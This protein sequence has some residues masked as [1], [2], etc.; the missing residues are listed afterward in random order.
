MMYDFSTTKAL[1]TV[2]MC[3]LRFLQHLLTVLIME[4]GHDIQP[5]MKA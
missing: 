3:L 1:A 5:Y 4:A 2:W